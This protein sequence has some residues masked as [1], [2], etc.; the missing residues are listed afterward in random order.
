VIKC[1]QAG[2]NVVWH[3]VEVVIEHWD[4]IGAINCVM[5]PEPTL[6]IVGIEGE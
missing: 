1:R 2:L 4:G 3:A 6:L 5:Y